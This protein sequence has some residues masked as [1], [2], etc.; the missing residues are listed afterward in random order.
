MKLIVKRDRNCLEKTEGEAVVDDSVPDYLKTPRVVRKDDVRALEQRLPNDDLLIVDNDDYSQIKEHFY[1]YE[2]MTKMEEMPGVWSGYRSTLVS[3]SKTGKLFRL[4]GVSLDPK[5]PKIVEFDDGAF[6]IEGGQKKQNAEYERTMSDR[7]NIVLANAGIA[8]VMQYRGIWTYPVLPKTNKPA[9]NPWELM[10][11][12]STEQ[13]RPTASIVE[14]E[15]DTRLDELMLVLENLYFGKCERY[16]DGRVCGMTTLKGGTCQ[17]AIY[18]FYFNIGIACGGLK[19]LMDDGRQTW[20]CDSQRS[21]AHI[22]NVVVYNG[23]DKL[24]VG[25]VDF[26]ASIPYERL[27]D[28]QIADLQKLEYETFAKSIMGGGISLRQINGKPFADPSKVSIASDFRERLANGFRWGYTLPSNAKMNEIDLGSM[29]EIFAL[30]RST[31]DFTVAEGTIREKTLTDIFGDDYFGLNRKGEIRSDYLSPSFS[32]IITKN[33]FY[34]DDLL[35]NCSNINNDNSL[36]YGIR[37]RKKGIRS[38]L[39]YT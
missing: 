24:R 10:G 20:S 32:D 13:N 35:E 37:K 31:G 9:R 15:G 25:L 6:W 4:K 16:S 27:S 23:T 18:D 21:N 14:V 26:D 11:G 34:Q 36:I 22:G 29:Q 19:R 3:D 8:P 38:L 7:F 17:R 2:W 28:S 30:L 1:N 39:N 12:I 5:D 33:K